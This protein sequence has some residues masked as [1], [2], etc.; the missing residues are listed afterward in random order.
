MESRTFE[1]FVAARGGALGRTAYLLTGD[2]QLAEDLVQTALGKAY[3]SWSRV[4]RADQPDAYVR[5]IMLN[6]YLAWWRRPR[7]REHLV[8]ELPVV[9]SSD[10]TASYAQA[11]QVREAIRTLPR[12]QRA[13]VVLRFYDDLP[14]AQIGELLGCAASTVR[15]QLSRALATLRTS[16]ALA[17]VAALSGKDAR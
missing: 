12:R 10:A 11:D 7:V 9:P 16:A 3:A 4:Q 1:E 5:R 13:V 15:S 2:R 14:E 8:D 6:A 17:D